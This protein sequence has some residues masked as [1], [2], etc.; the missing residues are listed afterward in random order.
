MFI[1]GIVIYTMGSWAA[2]QIAEN[3]CD[4]PINLLSTTNVILTKLPDNL[5]V[6]K[7]IPTKHCLNSNSLQLVILR[8]PNVNWHNLASIVHLLLTQIQE[9][10]HIWKTPSNSVH[11]S[12]IKIV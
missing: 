4:F 8:Q 1:K 10:L 12:K 7:M 9:L 11:F 6:Q 3:K 5:S 2:R